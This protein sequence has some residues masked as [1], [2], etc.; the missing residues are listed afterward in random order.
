MTKKSSAAAGVIRYPLKPASQNL[1][2]TYPTAYPDPGL[3]SDPPTCCDQTT[4]SVPVEIQANTRQKLTWAPGSGSTSTDG[5]VPPLK[6]SSPSSK[7]PA[8]ST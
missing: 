3:Q 7:T 8:R 5:S 1:P 2:Y 6:A 4:I